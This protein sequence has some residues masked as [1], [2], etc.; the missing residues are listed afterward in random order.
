MYLR[1]QRRAIERVGRSV[2]R[3]LECPVS[4]ESLRR[5]GLLRREAWMLRERPLPLSADLVRLGV[6]S[7]PEGWVRVP[8]R[9]V[10]GSRRAI[11]V[12]NECFGLD[13][14]DQAWNE[15]VSSESS[16]RSATWANT[17]TGYAGAFRHWRKWNRGTLQKGPPRSHKRWRHAGF[18]GVVRQA[19][20]SL[21]YDY[22]A[23]KREKKVWVLRDPEEVASRHGLGY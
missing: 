20:L 6:S 18:S 19:P 3:D 14:L 23:P 21:V 1:H 16:L 2:V 17:G 8:W 15:E 5:V 13:V 10:G 11:R 7:V 22:S 4:S 9:W 12:L